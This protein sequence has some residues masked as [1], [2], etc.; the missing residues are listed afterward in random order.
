MK[1]ISAP[2]LRA[3]PIARVQ[4]WPSRPS[5]MPMPSTALATMPIT[6]AMT[7]TIR[8]RCACWKSAREAS[9]GVMRSTWIA[10]GAG[11][12]RVHS[13]AGGRGCGNLAGMSELPPPDLRDQ[14]GRLRRLVLALIVGA[15]AGSAAYGILYAAIAP[16]EQHGYTQTVGTY[17][18][19]WYVTG[20]VFALAF[21]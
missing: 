11:Q 12:C 14:S 8:S 7:I 18:L 2:G 19:V 15:A 9:N 16:A 3:P 17:K 5:G 21:G 1:K 20:L 13:R 10:P 6:A 4:S